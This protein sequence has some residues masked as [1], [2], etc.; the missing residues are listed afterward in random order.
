VHHNVVQ[1][2]DFGQD[3]G[4]HYFS[5][6]WVRGGPLSDVVRDHG[7]VDPRV[8]ATYTLQAARGLQF[9]HRHGMVHRDVKPA[10]LLLNEE[11]VVK[12]ADLGLVKVP[13]QPD[14]E[15]DVA[16]A[17]ASSGMASG[18]QVTMMGTAV[19]TP[20]YMAPE[21]GLDAT[22]VDHRADI[23]SLGCSLFYF[24]TG[25]PP[26]DGSQV[27]EVMKQHAQAERPD[28]QKINHRVPDALGIVIKRSMA[29]RPEDRYASLAEM[30]LDLEAFLGLSSGKT[31]SPAQEQA[32]RWEQASKAYANV[33]LAKAVRPIV[34]AF[35]AVSLCF[36]LIT[37][38]LGL[39]FLLLAPSFIAATIGA[40]MTVA[41]L[42]GQSS[43]SN[44][45]V[46]R[47]RAWIGSLSWI[48]IAIGCVVAMVA[49]LLTFLIGLLPGL[50]TGILLGLLAGT[51]YSFALSRPLVQSREASLADA[52]K[53]VRD[54]RIQGVD[55]DAIRD[56]AARYAGK[57]WRPLFEAVFGYDAARQTQSALSKDSTHRSI[58]GGLS[59]RDRACDW[60]QSKIEANRV[61]RDHQRLAKL[62][63][64]GL[65]SEGLTDADAKERAW[66]MAS[67]MIDATKLSNQNTPASQDPKVETELR[68]A[69]MK[70]ML[71]DAR[72]GKYA[73][74]RSRFAPLHF[75]LGAK[76]R[77]LASCLLLAMAGM[78]AYQNEVVS[79]EAIRSLRDSATT[80]TVDVEA[81]KETMGQ[82]LAT[83]AND[84]SLPPLLG[85]SGWAVA[86]AGL[87]LLVS[88][89]AD[90]WRISL[91]VLPAVAI[92]LFAHQFGVP[93][94]GPVP[95]WAICCV[96]AMVVAIPGF[97][98]GGSKQTDY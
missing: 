71:A 55:E 81:L 48:D 89:L 23:Y 40:S 36:L 56:F 77:L 33:P 29:K 10:N 95:A 27:S 97:L 96:V 84:S 66:Q 94:V 76:V 30:I 80:G 69:K 13:D 88:S 24:L 61:A 14:P 93:A 34:A 52:E 9:A 65:K 5:M 83:A 35:A 51:A 63:E 44:V 15:S 45:I 21:Q 22:T 79:P 64:K 32:D 98:L 49:A 68:R 62:E 3:A 86:F 37:P 92:A 12:V 43:Q 2:Y 67:A 20:A 18:T 87:L 38:W 90:G 85:T 70:A 31:F 91:F 16:V 50:L 47:V 19:G 58:A 53:T 39:G 11:G 59:I 8:A 26:F 17:S 6:E 72:S 74:K 57:N 1:I 82:S 25:K 28:V 75:A 60:L 41:M 42:L 7:P 78:W 4:Q 46:T 73:R 54:L